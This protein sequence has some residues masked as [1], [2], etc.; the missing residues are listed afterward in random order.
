MRTFKKNITLM[1]QLIFKTS[2]DSNR[3]HDKIA[4]LLEADKL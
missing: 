1:K 4:A 2:L 3:D